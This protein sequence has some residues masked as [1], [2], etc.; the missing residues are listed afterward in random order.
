MNEHI[1]T[2]PLSVLGG[3]LHQSR[4]T[5]DLLHV[6][7]SHFPNVKAGFP[8]D[9][10]H[11]AVLDAEAGRKAVLLPLAP[12][13]AAPPP[14]Y[15]TN[16][17]QRSRRH[18]AWP[19]QPQPPLDPVFPRAGLQQHPPPLESFRGRWQ[20]PLPGTF[21]SWLPPQ[22]APL[23][24]SLEQPLSLCSSP[25]PG[26]PQAQHLLLSTILWFCCSLVLHLL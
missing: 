21:P 8:Q 11:H 12:F 9:L 18:E 20:F 1:P 5:Y 23:R 17:S 7:T 14:E 13:P 16:A 25:S 2:R 15:S 26:S 6:G 3:I 22:R 24:G 10:C 4:Q 19:R